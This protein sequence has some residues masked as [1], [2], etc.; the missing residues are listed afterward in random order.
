[1]KEGWRMV[2][3][4]EV[5][6]T[7]AGGTPSKLHKEYYEN[8]NIPWM[9]SGEVCHKY[10]YDVEHYITQ[11]GL[12]NSSAKL[13]PENTVVVAMY[14]AT[15]GQVGILKLET[16]TNQ[17]VCGILPNDNI[18]PEYLYYYFLYYKD[19]LVAQAVGNAQPNISQQKIKS[20][21]FPFL[22]IEDFI[23]ITF[24]PFSS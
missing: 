13:F 20:V 4:G 15:A 23:T 7:S 16:S 19:L 1:M 5:C 9:L 21:E 2:K 10:I 18:L 3:L 24:I 22:S 14:G 11:E 17:A 6:E 8:G 12:N